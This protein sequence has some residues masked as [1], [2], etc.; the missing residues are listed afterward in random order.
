MKARLIQETEAFLAALSAPLSNEEIKNGWSVQSQKAMSNFFAGIQADLMSGKNTDRSVLQG[1][2]RGLDHWGVEG[3]P[4]FETA[5]ALSNH[6]LE[7][8]C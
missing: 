6:L 8:E 4:L 2:V 5:C 1:I 3:G 7:L